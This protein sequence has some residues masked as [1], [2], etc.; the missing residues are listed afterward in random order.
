LNNIFQ[1][2]SILSIPQNNNK[3]KTVDKRRK[4]YKT[5]VIL[6]EDSYRAY[7]YRLKKFSRILAADVFKNKLRK[8]NK[9]SDIVSGQVNYRIINQYY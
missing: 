7:H 3:T 2:L 1:G 4:K 9:I 5:K 8:Y 6:K